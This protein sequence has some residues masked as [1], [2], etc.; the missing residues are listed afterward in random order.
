MKT[1]IKPKEGLLILN[2]ATRLN[3]RVEGELVDLGT[4]WRRRLS[5]G[6][7]ELVL[8]TKEEKIEDKK[9]S[10]LGGKK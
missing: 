4:Y 3:L 9:E 2:P 5:D 1:L 10:K 7:V 8:E 6:D